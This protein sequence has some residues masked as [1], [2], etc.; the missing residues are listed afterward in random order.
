MARRTAATEPWP[1]RT[2][3]ALRLR[4]QQGLLQVRT[5]A[6][7]RALVAQVGL[8]EAYA[9]TDV[10]AAADA[11]L[12]DQ[13]ALLL[14]LGPADPPIRLRELQLGGVAALVGGAA[15]DLVLPLGGALGDPSRRSGAQVL[16]DLIAGRQ[17][18]L[19]GLG[20]PTPLQPRLELSGSVGLAQ[21]GGGRL[22]LQ[23]AIV[24]NGLVAVSSGEGL[25]RSP[26]GPLLGP[27]VSALYSC[28][29]AGSIGLTMPGL[30]QLGPGSPV[31]VGG[32]IG[33]VVGPGSGHH[34]AV[35]RQP[36]GHA[37]G[38]GLCAAVMVELEL[39]PA[40]GVHS[41]F[42]EGHGA[43]LLV[44][45]AAPVP[46]LDAET[47]AQAAAGPDVLEAPVLDL[48][49]PRRIKPRL[50]H[51]SYAALQSGSFTLQGRQLRCAPAHSPRLAAAAADQLVELL[52]SGAMPLQEPLRPLSSRAGLVPL[53]L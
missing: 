17:L 27:L 7:Y 25:L 29:G 19:S 51:V 48:A 37:C 49:I 4:Q 34:P 2:L 10:V 52:C 44:P 16:T 46:L 39:L 33:M 38:P 40:A 18:G 31:L 20:E 14:S 45:I 6:A 36:S 30:R 41:C 1:Q 32:A 28:G 21:L 24:E 43:A 42:L 12:T 53:D 5:A 50:A 9:Q 22:L 13:G 8:Q 35:Q 15:A 3:A 47:A 11:V 23:R 26:L